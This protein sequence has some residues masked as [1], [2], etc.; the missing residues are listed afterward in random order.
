MNQEVA[1]LGSEEQPP[2][3][4]LEDGRVG[5]WVGE[6]MGVGLES[7]ELGYIENERFKARGLGGIFVTLITELE[8]LLYRQKRGG[9]GGK[10]GGKT[11]QVSL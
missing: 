5:L 7:L 8:L 2:A 9:K 3:A 11:I 1:L 4:G 10:N 6:E